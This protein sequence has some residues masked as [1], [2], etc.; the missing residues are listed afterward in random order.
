MT[1]TSLEATLKSLEKLYPKY[2]DLSLNRLNNL[3][4]KLDNPHLKLPKIIHIA[5]TNGKGST[6]SF[7]KYIL[8]EHNIKV[9]CYIS[10]HLESIEER[11][12]IR[13]KKIKKNKLLKALNYVKKINNNNKIT[14]FE[15]FTATAFYLFSKSKA[16]FLILETGLGGRLDAT[17]IVKKSL[18][19]IITPISY[20]H[21]EFLGK[22]L[23]KITNEKL[24]I[25]KEKSLIIIGK[26]KDFI[27]K[28]IYKKIKNYNNKTLFHEKNFK[29]INLK[30]KEFIIKINNKK[31][32]FIKPSLLGDHQFEN[33]LL[34]IV[35]C[36]EIKKIGYKIN[37]NKINR[38]LSKTKWPGRLEKIYK[39]NIE[40]FFD[41]AHNV[42]GAEQLNNYLSK[43]IKNT[44]V[45]IGMLKNKDIISFLK[46]IKNNI[47]GVIPIKIPNEKN[48]YTTKEISNACKKLRINYINK[49]NIESVKDYLFKIIK[50][51]RILITGSLYLIGKIKKK[52]I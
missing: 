7:I 8:T 13:N 23:K 44:W 28:H 16:E 20:D 5:G 47:N 42:G 11:I 38:A 32:T 12:V 52:L 10:P 24:G 21:Q 4:E 9:H 25:I 15:I 34:A 49:K 37:Y 33:A 27:T 31:L 46:I 1:S 26:Q 19:N 50:P 48:S 35:A 40:I 2:I 43:K 17:N 51:E 45:I 3:L 29:I 41:G 6:L 30:E 18:L 22:N 36:Y 14:F 39:K